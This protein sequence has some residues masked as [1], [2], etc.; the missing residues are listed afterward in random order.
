MSDK[1]KDQISDWLNKLER[2]SWQ[3]ELLVSAFTIF[4][5]IQ[6][7]ISFDDFITDLEY[8]YSFRSGALSMLYLFIGLLFKSL[9]AL[10]ICLITHLMLRGF[11][12]GTIGLRSVQSKI[13]FTDLKYNEFFTE[14]LKKNVISLDQLVIKLDEICSVI[15]AFAFLVIS[16]LLAFGMYLLFFG[17]IAV[18]LNLVADLT[19]EWL[20]PAITVTAL[21]VFPV[22]LLTGLIYMIDYLTLGFFKKIKWFA[23]VYYPFYK[24]YNFITLSVLS[25]SIYYYMISKFSK[26]R[27]RW[28]YALAGCLLFFTLIFKFDQHQYYPEKLNDL[29]ISANY[30]DDQR[31]LDDYVNQASIPS[32]YID[33]PYFRVFLRYDAVDNPRISEFCEGFTPIKDDGLNWRFKTTFENGN[34]NIGNQRYDDE[35]FEQLL[36]CLSAIYQLSVNDSVYD[37]LTYR[38]YTHPAKH[39][40]GIITNI[41]TDNFLKGENVLKIE[42]IQLDSAKTPQHEWFATIPFWYEK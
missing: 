37:D 30:Y 39:Q 34:L 21:I 14:K 4:L 28:I 26:K 17:L 32:D 35:D 10:T 3:L 41:P 38:F 7:T 23:R 5:L 25:R 12:I 36:S 6:A 31:P 29:A 24:L 20:D 27:I 22:V 2:E 15:F 18:V 11:W 8:Q 40:K 33:K 42:K 13:N 16:I 1:T 19:P 9:Q